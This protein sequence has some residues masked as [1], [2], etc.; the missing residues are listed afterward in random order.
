MK[1]C[2]RKKSI[3]LPSKCYTPLS[4]GYRP[5]LD[6]TAELK[7]ED[8]QWFQELIRMLRRAVEI[9]RVDILF[10]TAIMSKH[11]ALPREGHL[12]QLLHIYGYLKQKKKLRIAFDPDQPQINP[13]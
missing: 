10:K 7:A 4:S 1:K 9:G 6:A 8:V 2:Y 11:M 3:R 12:E 13:N 5:E